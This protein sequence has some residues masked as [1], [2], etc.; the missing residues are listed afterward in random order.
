[1]LALTRR[2]KYLLAELSSGETLM[3]HL[4]MSGSFDIH[5]VKTTL[6]RRAIEAWRGRTVTTT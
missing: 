4:G 2:A 6:D 1:M 5:L 3:M